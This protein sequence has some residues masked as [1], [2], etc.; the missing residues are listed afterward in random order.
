[1]N[2]LDDKKL[3]LHNSNAL[4]EDG[5][6]LPVEVNLNPLKEK[7]FPNESNSTLTSKHPYGPWIP[8]QKNSNQQKYFL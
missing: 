5:R 2:C 8:V 4:E 3:S 7:E 6:E 1:M